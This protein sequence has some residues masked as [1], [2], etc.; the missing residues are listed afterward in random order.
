[1][2]GGDGKKVKVAKG[3]ATS[4]GVHEDNFYGNRWEEKRVKRGMSRS[5]TK[6]GVEKEA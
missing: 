3:C 5:T 4:I 6:H 2:L 1:M